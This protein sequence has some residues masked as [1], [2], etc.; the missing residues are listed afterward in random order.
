[1]VDEVDVL[2]DEERLRQVVVDED[3]V[4]VPDVLEVLKRPGV[5]VVDADDPVLLR[6][7]VVAEVRPQEACPARDDGGSDPLILVRTS[8]FSTAN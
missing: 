2:L 1:V 8:A 4:P 6:E 3:E 7:Q 5:E